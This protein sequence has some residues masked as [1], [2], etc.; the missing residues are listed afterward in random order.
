MNLPTVSE[1]EQAR[2]ERWLRKTHVHA[3]LA[4]LAG[5]GSVND[6]SFAR[7]LGRR[8]LPTLMLASKP[9][10]GSYT[11]YGLVIRMPAI[12]ES[13]AAWMEVLDLV[14]SRLAGPAVLFAT[15]DEH[16]LWVARQ[17]EHLSRSF[18]FLL[19][20]AETVERIVNKRDQYWVAKAAGIPIPKTFYPESVADVRQLLDTL[21]YPVILKPQRAHLGRRRLANRKVLVLNS[22]QE[23]LSAYIDLADGGPFMIQDIIPGGDDALF[24]YSAF[25][26]EDGREW[27]WLT[28]QKLRQFPPTFGDG[29]FQRTVDVPAVA[30]LSRRLLSAFNYRGLV[31]VEFKWDVRDETYR[32]MEINARTVSGNQLAISA[33]IDFPWIAY[34]HLTG[35]KDDPA[36]SFQTQ[37]K[38]VN[39]E[40]DVQAYWAL[41]QRRQLS[42]WSWIRSLR[43]TKAWA[44]SAVDDPFPLLVGIWRFVARLFAGVFSGPTAGGFN[45]SPRG[46]Q[47]VDAVTEKDR[48]ARAS[49]Q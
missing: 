10:L 5:N 39:E 8:G 22:P 46:N 26:D 29:S 18:R 47:P 37:I 45:Q 35:F 49:R 28:R 30:D 2:L 23:L 33:G 40:W 4:V 25:W 31:G 43:G 12:E 17:A 3:P 24:S 20:S 16:C 41:R 14:A 38:Y 6:L 11:R 44:L 48:G 27:A 15:A 36:P 19:P 21:S 32:L 13:P 9:L 42:F 34:R 7:S 1:R